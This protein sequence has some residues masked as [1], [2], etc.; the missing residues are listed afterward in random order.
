MN[1]KVSVI[2]PVYNVE[3]YLERC[4]HS[5]CNQTFKDIEIIC[6]NDGST[7]KSLEILNLFAQEDHRIK[8]LDKMNTGVSDCRNK[9]L[10]M[11]IG[12]YVMFVDSDD[13]IDVNMVERMYS[14]MTEYNL[15][16]S[17]CTYCREFIGYSKEKNFDV[18]KLNLYTDDE[19]K[20]LIRKLIGPLK[21]ELS[22]PEYLD[23]LGTVWGKLYKTDLIKR[24]NLKFVDLNEIGSAEDVLFNIYYMYQANNVIFLNEPF[25]HYWRDNNSS[26][27]SKYNKN[28]VNQR[29]RFFEYI[30]QFIETNRLSK[31]Y[32]KSLNNRIS[33]S[34]LGLGFNELSEDNQISFFKKY[35]NFR[36]ILNTPYI[37]KSNKDLELRYF[38]LHW[39]L[40]YL[41]NKLRL[42]ILSFG[43]ILIINFLRK[44]I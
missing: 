34:V 5:I 16:L 8:I 38:Q 42:T 28:L 32:I 41:F 15:D 13:W 10:D 29:Q 30:N 27:T 20:I 17:M 4:L 11:A 2:I 18:P 37:I 36:S 6:V 25:Y 44:K 39:R 26:I 9:A 33:I 22:N 31:D 24:N 40:F 3:K 12:Q 43:M 7:D 19:V 35:Q 21:E 23:A 1:V 14:L